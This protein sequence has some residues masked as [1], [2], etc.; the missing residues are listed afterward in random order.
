MAKTIV[1]I[2]DG[3]KITVSDLIGAP[4]VI[5]TRAIDLVRDNLVAETLFRNGGS[6][7]SPVVQFTRSAPVF[8]DG[9]PEIVGEFGEIPVAGSGEGQPEVA[10][11]HKLGLAN[12][13]SREMK[14]YNQIQL[15][16]KNLTRTTNTFIRAND[17]LAQKALADAGVPEIPASDTWGGS[18]SNP[19]SDIA[20]A[21]ESVNGALHDNNPN[22]PYGY[23][24]DTIVMNPALWP[25]LMDDDRFSK[26]YNGDAA[27]EHIGFKG[28]L[29]G[30]LMSCNVL[31]SRFWPTDKVLVLQRGITGFYADPRPLEATGLYPEGGGPNGGPT[32]S[33]RSDMT[34]IRIIGVDEPLSACWITGIA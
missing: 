3:N 7:A 25:V 24:A 31:Q 27:S 34:Q 8:L 29:P 4:D 20:A 15:V 30:S 19:R 9:D 11:G 32:E 26:L 14:D 6:P 10:V 2:H 33:W 5:P 22:E 16:L 21:I 23:V 1:S 18:T 12:R 28:A 17:K 13:I